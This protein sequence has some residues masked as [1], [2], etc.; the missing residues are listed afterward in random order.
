MV[1]GITRI[2]GKVSLKIRL[3]VWSSHCEVHTVNGFFVLFDGPIGS[4]ASV[5]DAVL[6]IIYHWKS[7]VTGLLVRD[8][9]C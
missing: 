9:Q 1:I 7:A 8:F 3:I 4:F 6:M 5:N 2:A